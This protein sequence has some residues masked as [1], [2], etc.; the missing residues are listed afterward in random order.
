[1]SR[2]VRI[3]FR[4]CWASVTMSVMAV[5]WLAVTALLLP[6][7]LAA[8]L[9]VRSRAVAPVPMSKPAHLGEGIM[10]D[11]RGDRS[12]LV[13]T[14][15][16]G[17]EYEWMLFASALA[18][19]FGAIPSGAT[20]LDVG[21]GSLREAYDLALRG[22]SVAAADMDAKAMLAAYG[23]YDWDAAPG[24][25]RLLSGSA[26]TLLAGSDRF[27]LVVAFDVLEHVEHL[28]RT[29]DA[30]RVLLKPRGMV[31]VSV[32]NRRSVFER[33]FR[34]VHLRRVS[35]GESIVYGPPHVRFFSPEEWAGVFARSGFKV[36]SRDMAIGPLVNDV[37]HGLFGLC[38][39]TVVAP[40]VQSA[41]ERVGRGNAYA[42]EQALWYPGWLM[43]RV[44][45]LD[46]L[47]ERPLRG[48]HGWC[49]FVLET[50]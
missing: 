37:Y 47:L 17:A 39:R 4:L 3:L 35:R 44:E 28:D 45:R 24:A 41:L 33:Y 43:R 5:V 22:F 11:R 19:R 10:F 46:R 29:L 49:L 38:W 15:S 25:C 48:W 27:D 23:S 40:V 16:R 21:A 14:R 8:G 9:V 42:W 30:I 13:G 50:A 2:L 36:S 31:F 6:L 18:A 12:K 26:E 32:P 1:M 34:R 7:A 20:A